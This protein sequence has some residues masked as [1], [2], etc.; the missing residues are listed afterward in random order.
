MATSAFSGKMKE[1]RH[2]G[3]VT[4]AMLPSPRRPSPT[5][6][7]LI[8]QGPGKGELG[9]ED[10]SSGAPA[11]RQASQVFPMTRAWAHTS[12]VNRHRPHLRAGGI[13]APL[14]LPVCC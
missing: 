7:H 9:S 3:N 2:E 11:R 6:G 8:K 10:L 14:R 1:Q 4:G 5:L 12:W 13:P